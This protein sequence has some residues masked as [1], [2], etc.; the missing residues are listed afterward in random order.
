M[1]GIF[2]SSIIRCWTIVFVVYFSYFL[3][4]QMI[5]V[6]PSPKTSKKTFWHTSIMKH[7]SEQHYHV[8]VIN[9]RINERLG[10]K[11]GGEKKGAMSL[12]TSCPRGRTGAVQPVKLGKGNHEYRYFT[13]S[14]HWR[15]TWISLIQRTIDEK[16]WHLLLKERTAEINPGKL[17]WKGTN[18]IIVAFN[19]MYLCFFLGRW[20]SLSLFKSYMFPFTSHGKSMF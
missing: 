16:E 5:P 15:H 9:A 19:K 20:F 18:E 13:V 7:G 4:C 1:E 8:R 3:Y 14:L 11:K 2:P 10:G 12:V 17:Y 6:A